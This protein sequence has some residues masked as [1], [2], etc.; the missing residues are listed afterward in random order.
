M[1]DESYK[2]AFHA[3]VD[4]FY[5]LVTR[6]DALIAEL[7]AVEDRME[8]VRQGVMGIAPLA[9][10]DFEELRVKYPELFEGRVD[11]NVGITEA[12][13]ESLRS[14]DQALTPREIR[15][16]VIQLSPVVAGHSNP[17]ASIHAILRRL[18]DTDEIISFVDSLD[19]TMYGWV[20]LDE[21]AAM[22]RLNRWITNPERTWKRIQQSRKKKV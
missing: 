6:R 14:T 10:M 12:V 15:D 20:P 2:K 13:R 4:E 3:G 22:E 5:V 7:E 11:P 1:I 17:M 9:N 16:R 18:M 8:R 19:R 21:D